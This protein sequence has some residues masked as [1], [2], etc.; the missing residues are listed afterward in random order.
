MHLL[1]VF[2]SF[3]YGTK[4]KIKAIRP[5]IGDPENISFTDVVAW[6]RHDFF[7][8]PCVIFRFIFWMSIKKVCIEDES[9]DNRGSSQYCFFE[10][11]ELASSGR[12][13][14]SRD[15]QKQSRLRAE[16]TRSHYRRRLCRTSNAMH[17]EITLL[18]P[19]RYRAVLLYMHAYATTVLRLGSEYRQPIIPTLMVTKFK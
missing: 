11:E 4:M 12:Q 10:F 16:S 1:H 17:H 3:I 18:L 19:D 7:T 8:I 6:I 5:H 14:A 9:S 15:L 13:S 2:M